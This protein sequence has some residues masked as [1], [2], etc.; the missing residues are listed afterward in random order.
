MRGYFNWTRVIAKEAPAASDVT[1]GDQDE[2]SSTIGDTKT[3]ITPTG[4]NEAKNTARPPK[5]NTLQRQH[6]FVL[7]GSEHVKKEPD[8]GSIK[9]SPAILEEPPSKQLGHESTNSSNKNLTDDR[10]I[11]P[12]TDN[13]SATKVIGLTQKMT[14]LDHKE[15]QYNKT[16][17]PTE[18]EVDADTK[19]G[20]Q[21]SEINT[22]VIPTSSTPQFAATQSKPNRPLRQGIFGQTDI[23]YNTT[24]DF[25][26]GESNI[27]NIPALPVTAHVLGKLPTKQTVNS[28]TSQLPE[29][30]PI[31]TYSQQYRIP[32]ASMTNQNV[33]YTVPN[34]P[35]MAGE[36]RAV[37]TAPSTRKNSDG[38][39]GHT[40]NPDDPDHRKALMFLEK[41]KNPL[42]SLFKKL[43][44]QMLYINKNGY[45]A[46]EK[47][48]VGGYGVV[49]KALQPNGQL[50]AIKLMST[51]K[52]GTEYNKLEEETNYKAMIDEIEIM[53]RLK[54]KGICLDLVDYEIVVKHAPALRRIALI[55]M[56][57]GDTDLRSF[58]KDFKSVKDGR[59]VGPLHPCNLLPESKIL[60]LLYDMITVLHRMHM[61]GYIHCDLKPQNFMF[62][63]GRLRLIDFGIS[64]AMQ[65]NTTC[66]FTDTIAGT[67]KYMAPEIM[68]T[69]VG[70]VDSRR[71]ELH[72]VADV[73][74]IGCILFEMAAGYH[75]LDRYVDKHP[76]T[77]LRVVA[78]RKYT[79]ESDDLHV[80]PELKE[81]IMLCLEHSPNER[82]TME[83]IFDHACLKN[84]FSQNAASDFQ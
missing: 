3:C 15:F 52:S 1:E 64:K 45:F 14:I 72:R 65:Q 17:G 60:S 25:Q 56:E 4:Q 63:K 23:N 77:L 36:S 24:I 80:S 8:N 2:I 37:I 31:N 18:I 62:Y 33:T 70:A 51:Q 11:S 9:K 46:F 54:G 84:Q 73:W 29:Q 21:S 38:S 26:S 10:L 58:M 74:S 81:L 40:Y 41:Y 79:I 35:T 66:A 68:P 30:Q 12:Q 44:V 71:T 16:L 49:Y 5:P 22:S 67:P 42:A 55:A 78:E 7:Q 13:A 32:I 83:G 48:G 76:L 57:L 43:P 6:S 19:I 28:N 47:I 50:C 75:P 61:Q 20:T 82:I 27:S 53:K 69:L 59:V 39:S 34:Q